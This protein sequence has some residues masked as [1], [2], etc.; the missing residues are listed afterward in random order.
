MKEKPIK[1]SFVGVRLD[2][3]L[4]EKLLREKERIEA[5]L[6]IEVSLT[7]VIRKIINQ[8]P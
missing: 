2:S 8:L 6:N 3:N 5:E 7:L 1:T 4:M